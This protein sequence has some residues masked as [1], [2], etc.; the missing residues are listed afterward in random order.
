[1]QVTKSFVQHYVTPVCPVTTNTREI[2][3]FAFQTKNPWGLLLIIVI[4]WVDG[5]FSPRGKA[6]SRLTTHF[7]RVPR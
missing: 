5:T 7:H 4:V 1:M 3:K 6:R 2:N